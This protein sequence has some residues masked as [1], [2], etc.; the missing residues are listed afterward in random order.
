MYMKPCQIW[1]ILS[2]STAVDLI[3]TFEHTVLSTLLLHTL[4]P[5][6]PHPFVLLLLA[7]RRVL[8][9]IEFSGRAGGR[10]G[11]RAGGSAR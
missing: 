7:P 2:F 5:R 4:H 3:M 1:V 9:T 11:G 10:V 8:R 6:R